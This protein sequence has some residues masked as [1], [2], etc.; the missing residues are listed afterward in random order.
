MRGPAYTQREEVGPHPHF[1]IPTEHVLGMRAEPPAGCESLPLFSGSPTYRK[2][3][4]TTSCHV[5]ADEIMIPGRH[6][7]SLSHHSPAQPNEDRQASSILWT[8]LNVGAERGLSLCSSERPSSVVQGTASRSGI[9][10]PPLDSE[11]L[12]LT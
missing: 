6:H 8:P 12:S 9:P 1:P 3:G 11:T 2:L 10:K 7:H 4:S 5:P